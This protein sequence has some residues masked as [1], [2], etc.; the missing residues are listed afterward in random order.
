MAMCVYLIEQLS[1]LIWLN[2]FLFQNTP[3]IME[4]LLS[5]VEIT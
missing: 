1:C 5:I 4:L 2:H 3:F